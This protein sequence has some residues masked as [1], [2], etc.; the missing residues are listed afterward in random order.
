MTTFDLHG[1]RTGN[2][3]RAAIALAE[4]GLP[5]KAVPVD[6][7]R[8]EHRS[9]AFA[10]LNPLGKVPVLVIDDGDGPWALSQSGA[11][12]LEVARRAGERLMPREPRANALAL[13]RFFYFITDVIEPSHAGFFLARD[14]EQAGAVALHRLVVERIHAAD[15]FLSRSPWMSGQHFSLADI[16][17]YTLI[18]AEGEHVDW[19]AHPTLSSW[20]GRVATRPAVKL[21]LAAFD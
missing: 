5:F 4:S 20:Y 3:L 6:L 15:A 11:I 1:A 21:G 18:T 16:A 17:A 2:S 7:R 19:D 12:M 14:D 13:E 8:G 10:A 9:N